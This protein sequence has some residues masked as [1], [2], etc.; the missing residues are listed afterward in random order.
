[1]VL[2]VVSFRWPETQRLKPIAFSLILVLIA[3]SV[4]RLFTRKVSVVAFAMNWTAN[5]V[6]PWGTVERDE[7]GAV[8]V[9]IYRKVDGGYCYDAVFSPELKARLDGPNKVINVEYNVFSD[10]G[11]RRGYNIRSID[12]LIFNEGERP[13]RTGETYGGYIM[14]S[15]A[16]N[17]WR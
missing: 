16:A 15:D 13:V 1:M 9:V 11:L 10:F 6:A 14:G 2:I 3:F 4:D 5:G 8:P 17:C 7:K 12:G